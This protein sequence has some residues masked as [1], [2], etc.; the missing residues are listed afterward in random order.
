[1][2]IEIRKDNLIMHRYTLLFNNKCK[3]QYLINQRV[4]DSQPTDN[5]L[6]VQTDATLCA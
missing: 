6:M 2:L 3:S 4:E 1:M 5:F